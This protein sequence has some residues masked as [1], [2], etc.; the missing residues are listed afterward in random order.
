VAGKGLSDTNYT[1]DEKTKLAGIANGAQVNPGVATASADGLMS[2]GDKSR[3]DTLNPPGTVIQTFIRS[4]AVRAQKRL[5]D[6]TGQIISITGTYAEL[7]ANVYC[8]DALNATEPWFYKCDASGNR[9]TSGA[10][11]KMPDCRGLFLRGAG[12]NSMYKGANDTPYDGKSIGA[13]I[14]DAI[15]DIKGQVNGSIVANEWEGL[16]SSPTGAFYVFDRNSVPR[17]AVRSLV[18][19]TPPNKELGFAASYSVPTSHENRPA[20]ISA[21]VCITY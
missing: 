3:L 6:L 9:T 20:S 14:P 15:R 18:T 1:Q 16:F 17:M 13:Y 12:A 21:M 8:G 2:A 4:A 7:A 5:L 11:M 19:D 10:Y